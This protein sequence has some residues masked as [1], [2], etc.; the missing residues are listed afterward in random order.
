MKIQ[1]EKKAARSERFLQHHELRKEQVAELLKDL[2]RSSSLPGRTPQKSV[3]EPVTSVNNNTC[4]PHKT[5]GLSSD[6]FFSYNRALSDI[7]EDDDENLSQI[8]EEYEENINGRTFSVPDVSP[9][10]LEATFTVPDIPLGSTVTLKPTE[11]KISFGSTTTIVFPDYENDSKSTQEPQYDIHRSGSYSKLLPLQTPYLQASDE[12]HV[13]GINPK[14]IRSLQKL[15][16]TKRLPLKVLEA[17]LSQQKLRDAKTSEPY[18]VKHF[19]QRIK[20]QSHTLGNNFK[21][22]PKSPEQ[23]NVRDRKMTTTPRQKPSIYRYKP[24]ESPYEGVKVTNVDVSDS[25]ETLSSW[26]IPDDIRNIIYGNLGPQQEGTDIDNTSIGSFS[27]QSTSSHGHRQSSY[28][29]ITNTD[30]G[31]VDKMISRIGDD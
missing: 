8:T 28:T 21:H 13:I 24:Y 17:E 11:K 22:P 2:T 26:S 5:V 3:Q 15:Y 27:D 16:G 4:F 19:S 7:Q 6:L 31:V 20:Q 12:I 30:E 25:S 23:P 18:H 10:D 9:L 14:R 1:Q 29:P